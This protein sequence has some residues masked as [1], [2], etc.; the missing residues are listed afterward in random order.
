MKVNIHIWFILGFLAKS[1][2][3]WSENC[4]SNLGSLKQFS[5]SHIKVYMEPIDWTESVT[6]DFSRT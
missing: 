2:K 1:V 3:K 5:Q 6:F 4:N